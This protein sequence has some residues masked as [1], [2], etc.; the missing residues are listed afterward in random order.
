MKHLVDAALALCFDVY[1]LMS[2]CEYELVC[3]VLLIV[4]GVQFPHP[5]HFY[6]TCPLLILFLLF[7][8]SL[9]TMLSLF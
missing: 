4:L 9:F 2:L 3:R 7:C 1:K 5:L 8:L 6:L